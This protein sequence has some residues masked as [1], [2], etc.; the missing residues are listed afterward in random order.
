[1]ESE[2]GRL[3]S[4]IHERQVK[5]NW[6]DFGELCGVNKHKLD[7]FYLAYKDS[8]EPGKCLLT[9]LLS[10]NPDF[11]FREIIVKLRQIGREDIIQDAICIYMHNT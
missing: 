6:R 3:L 5:K 10:S 1:M 7:D 11:L 8:R 4:H 2:L 9:Y